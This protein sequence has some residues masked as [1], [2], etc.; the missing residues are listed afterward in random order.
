MTCPTAAFDLTG[1]PADENELTEEPIE[2]FGVVFSETPARP[3]VRGSFEEQR[4]AKAKVLTSKSSHTGVHHLRGP[5][6]LEN[7]NSTKNQKNH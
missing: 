4:I 5:P 3:S 7:G 6:I 2:G 1:D